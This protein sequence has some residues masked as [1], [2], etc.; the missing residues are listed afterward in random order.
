[1]SKIKCL[2]SLKSE[3]QY[4]SK[5]RK[6]GEKNSIIKG[7]KIGGK[8]KPAAGFEML[9]P[10]WALFTVN[11]EIECVAYLMGIVFIVQH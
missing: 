8:A 5:E 1:M 10:G 6:T 9:S 11:R 7:Q 2:A 4:K 3:G